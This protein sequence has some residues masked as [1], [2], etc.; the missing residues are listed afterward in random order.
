MRR[1]REVDQLAPRGPVSRDSADCCLLR[2]VFVAHSWPKRR[3]D[4]WL[5]HAERARHRSEK[6]VQMR[7]F[8]GVRRRASLYI[9]HGNL[10]RVPVRAGNSRKPSEP[11]EN[12]LVCGAFVRRGTRHCQHSARLRR[13]SRSR[14]GEAAY[15]GIRPGARLRGL[16]VGR[17]PRLA[18]PLASLQQERKAGRCHRQFAARSIASSRRRRAST[19][20]EINREGGDTLPPSSRL[21]G[22][23]GPGTASSIEALAARLPGGNDL[24]SRSGVERMLVVAIGVHREDRC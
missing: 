21:P 4:D 20:R 11:G 3:L 24:E 9:P 16:Q 13:W 22:R 17:R 6:R 14:P 18:G 23:G 2:Q 10:S 1:S 8:G 15:A 19:D 7:L 12:V 5:N